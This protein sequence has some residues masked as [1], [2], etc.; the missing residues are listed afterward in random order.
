MVLKEPICPYFNH[1]AF[2]LEITWGNGL[3][4]NQGVLQFYCVSAV[5]E[6]MWLFCTVE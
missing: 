5:L 1:V 2:I 3:E 4:R 6:Q